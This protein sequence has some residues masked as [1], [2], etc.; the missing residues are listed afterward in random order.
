MFD[1]VWKLISGGQGL[2]DQASQECI[3]MLI[4]GKEMFILAND[5]VR[6]QTTR[7]LMRTLARMDKNLNKKEMEVR[8]KIFS[9][10][11]ISRGEDLLTGLQLNI[12]ATDLERIGD[13]TKNIGELVEMLP[14]KLDFGRHDKTFN[15]VQGLSLELFDLTYKAL[16][17]RDENLASEV[18]RK[19]DVVSKTVDDC[20]KS[21]VT[22]KEL[23]ETVEKRHVGLVLLLRH[24]K[25]VC[26]HL[27]NISTSLVNP[28]HQIG[29]RPGTYKV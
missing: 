26:A 21:V 7:E 10:L 16:E 20:I 9:H 17:N 29:Y 18:I 22:G 6:H 3:D 2:I 19:Y 5:A 28:F 1:K 25:R 13:Y 24:I 12:I 4:L 14:G 15:T 27:K 8:K 23:S 11:A